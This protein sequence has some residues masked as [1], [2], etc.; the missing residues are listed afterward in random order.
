MSE[1]KTGRG[2]P[3]KN[4]NIIEVNNIK[5]EFIITKTDNYEN[6]ISYLKII[7]KAFKNKLQPILSQVCDDCKV[8]VWKSDDGFYMLK[9]KKKWMPEKD[10]ESNEI[11]TADLN[12][13]FY[14]L[15]KEDGDLI[16][17]YY[18]KLSTNDDNEI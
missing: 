8:P 12:F 15:A 17:G 6:D 7:D 3:K 10:F 9:V 18:V 16:M 5:L 14:Q 13:H 4:N 1:S 11:I 2:R